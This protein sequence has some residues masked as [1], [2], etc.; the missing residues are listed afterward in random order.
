MGGPILYI[1]TAPPPTHTLQTQLYGICL[2]L[3]QGMGGGEGHW[4]ECLSM[5]QVF[6]SSWI[7]SKERLHYLDS[8]QWGLG[9]PK[10]GPVSLICWGL[11]CLSRRLGWGTG[12]PPD[13]RMADS[14][15]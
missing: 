1:W 5:R 6:S 2:G 15:V 10:I 11:L 8:V 13:R 9:L 3:V 7:L 12:G 4:D 14:Q